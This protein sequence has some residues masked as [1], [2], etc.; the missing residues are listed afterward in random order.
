MTCHALQAVDP[1]D[2]PGSRRAC[3]CIIYARGPR[4]E[5]S[6]SPAGGGSMDEIVAVVETGVYVDDLGRAE[7][8]YGRVLGLE[9][10][11]R[12]AGRHVFFRV[13]SGNVLL[14]FLARA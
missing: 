8:F 5:S 3:V 12:E 10:I 1:V 14:A 7:E 6:S 2:A 4:R 13:G 11:G 9:V